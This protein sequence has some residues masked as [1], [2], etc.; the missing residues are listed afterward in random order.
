MVIVGACAS[1]QQWERLQMLLH[2]SI[3]EFFHNSVW[4]L[5]TLT[6]IKM[7]NNLYPILAKITVSFMVIYCASRRMIR[8]TIY[9]ENAP[10]S[11]MTYH[12]IRFFVFSPFCRRKPCQTIW[13][14]E[15]SCSV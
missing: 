10:S 6:S 14:K 4:L 7:F 9:F 13:D 2:Q 8:F 1:G 3:E 5:V 12:K 15:H 11:L